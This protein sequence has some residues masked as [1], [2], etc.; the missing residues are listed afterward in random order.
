M[1]KVP[2]QRLATSI[3][4][5]VS[6]RTP[7][8]Y[9][10]IARELSASRAKKP[11]KFLAMGS[12]ILKLK[13]EMRETLA[14]PRTG[15]RA[16]TF[17][18]AAAT[19]DLLDLLAQIIQWYITHRRSPLAEESG[20]EDTIKSTSAK[21]MS[22]AAF[23]ESIGGVDLSHGTEFQQK[24]WRY[25][26]SDCPGVECRSYQDLSMKLF[27]DSAHSRAVGRACASNRISLLVPCHRVVRRAP[28]MK[29]NKAKPRTDEDGYRWGRWRKEK[30]LDWELEEGLKTL[31]V[32][33]L[34]V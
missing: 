27:G 33:G 23:V 7:L 10:I 18:Q 9:L 20:D 2:R 14:P 22:D 19:S 17:S 1:P 26:I 4:Y 5:A 28:T 32:C 34:A 30:L 11:I 24:V 13:R 6:D 3:E 15:Q 12:D 31:S 25:L 8:D 29:D 16:W 21:P